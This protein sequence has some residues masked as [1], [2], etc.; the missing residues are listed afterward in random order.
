[1]ITDRG[2]GIPDEILYQVFTPFFTTKPDGLGL[3]LNICKTIVEAH[4]GH[5]VVE[6]HK[7][8]G[9]VFSLT[10]PIST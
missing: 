10:L 3:G 5:I 8:G 9:A 7:D 4:G 1:V 2:K 6:N